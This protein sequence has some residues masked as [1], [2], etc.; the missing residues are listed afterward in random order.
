MATDEYTTAGSYTWTCPSN[1]SS[2]QIEC[3]GAG[4]AGCSES[5]EGGY[6]AGAGGGGGAYS[7]KNSYSV[8]P[9]SGYTVN[10][11]AGGTYSTTY[12]TDGGDTYFV[13]TAVCMAKGGTH[14]SAWNT[15]GVGGSASS[16]VGDTKYNGG[17]AGES[18]SSNGWGGGG[19]SSAGTASAG[20]YTSLNTQNQNAGTQV[21]G[22]GYGGAGGD[23]VPSGG[24]TGQNGGSPGG[25]GGGNG[26]N[27]GGGWNHGGSGG[28]GKVL[29]TYSTATAPT[30]TTTTASSITVNTA[31]SGGNV[32]SDGGASVTARGVVWNRTG[33]PT[34]ASYLGKTTDG[35]G[36]G[37][38]TSSLTSLQVTTKYY[39][40]AYATNSVGTSYGSESNFTTLAIEPP[41]I[42]TPVSYPAKLTIPTQ[43]YGTMSM[44]IEATNAMSYST[45]ASLLEPSI[46]IGLPKPQIELSLPDII[47]IRVDWL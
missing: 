18:S 1:V 5:L 29:L 6:G 33:T 3:W 47:H 7:K 25:G 14:G 40:R 41:T 43:V 8:T 12:G 46:E 30:V 9:G 17:N 16:S 45:M 27:D 23:A 35:S 38:F 34:I 32:T 19:G 37:S 15:G 39:Y 36:T 26:Y 31:S 28:A 13:S 10:V 11:G 20:N 22:G 21:S 44:I 24:G 42:V 2:V 4:G